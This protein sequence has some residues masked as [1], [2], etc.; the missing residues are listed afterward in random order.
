MRTVIG[1]INRGLRQ[2]GGHTDFSPSQLEVFGTIARR[3]DLRMSEL[4][5]R[6]GINPTLL[7]RIV[8]KLEEAGLVT[9]T[10]DPDDRRVWHVS[11][12]DHGRSMY[13]QIRDERTDTLDMAIAELSPSERKALAA[14]LPALETLSQTLK[15]R[16]L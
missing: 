9:R 7:S 16:T 5:E 8:A 4:A 6:E 10:P 2:A 13:V 11:P 3:G 12:T 1:R 15:N 14:A